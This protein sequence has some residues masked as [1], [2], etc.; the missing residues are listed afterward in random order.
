MFD[1]LNGSLTGFVQ[2]DDISR[3]LHDYENQSLQQEHS[4]VQQSID[5]L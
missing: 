2:L 3:H 4:S 1:K 5:G